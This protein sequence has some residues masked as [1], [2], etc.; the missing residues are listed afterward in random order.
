MWESKVSA[1]LPLG[2]PAMSFHVRLTAVVIGAGLLA[3]AATGC[4][5]S[6]PSAAPTVT[7]TVTVATPAP[8]S[9]I[10]PGDSDT[11]AS[12]IC[13]QFSAFF[14]VETNATSDAKSGTITKAVEAAELSS[15]VT[16]MKEATS[17]D[18]GIQNAQTKLAAALAAPNSSA[19]GLPYDP[20]SSMYRSAQQQLVRACSAAGSKISEYANVGG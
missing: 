17:T 9:T 16:G 10:Q 19:P 11:S 18:S 15:I 12:A 2:G 3:V 4:A 1:T 14:T 6:T 13:G 20:T 5:S 8:A 7:K